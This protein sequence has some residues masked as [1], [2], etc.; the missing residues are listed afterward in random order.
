MTIRYDRPRMSGT[1][2]AADAPIFEVDMG[3]D[4]YFLGRAKY[5]GI[6]ITERMVDESGND[7]GRTYAFRYP[8]DVADAEGRRALDLGAGYYTEGMGYTDGSDREK[9]VDCFRAAE[10]LY[11]HAAER[12]NPCAYLD[13]GYV[14]SYDRCEGRYY[15]D[16]RA[17]KAGEGCARSCPVGQRAFECFSE[18]AGCGM[19]EGCYKLGDLYRQ[20]IGC[21][22][23]AAT[24]FDL[25]AR[26]FELG[27]E[28]DPVVWGSIALR[29]G[30]CFE[31]GIGCAQGFSRA[32]EWYR[33]A[34]VG[35]DAAVRAGEWFYE[36]ALAH[37]RSGVRRMGQ[38]L[39]GGY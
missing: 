4:D 29:L 9:R 35:L 37:A 28:D 22:P 38:E 21:S 36:R 10:L 23:D 26:A 15:Q 5:P 33:K 20:G 17:A 24:A 3:D 7:L 39:D 30:D 13:L 31:N 16:L 34:E 19:A 14:Y 32:L 27:R 18:A 1:G 11:L 25:Y 2:L 12:G 6:W 8:L